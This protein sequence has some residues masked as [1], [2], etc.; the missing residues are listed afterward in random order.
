MQYIETGGLDLETFLL[1]ASIA[2]V[3]VSSTFS[4][5]KFERDSLLKNVVPSIREYARGRGLE[6][7][8]LDLRWGIRDQAEDNHEIVDLCLQQ[9]RACQLLSPHLNFVS[10]LGHKYGYRPIPTRIEKIEFEA[11]LE[12][13]T[14]AEDDELLRKWY[15]EDTNMVLCLCKHHGADMEKGNSR[16]KAILI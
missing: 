7:Q 14:A 3:F 11:I 13:C 9:L 6:F 15:N 16:R 2:Q 1:L 8:F 4:D 12:Y 5:T 10:L